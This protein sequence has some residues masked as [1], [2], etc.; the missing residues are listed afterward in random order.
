MDE[1]RDVLITRRRLLATGAVVAAS[2]ALPATSA[3]AKTSSTAAGRAEPLPRYPRTGYRRSRFAPHV[4]TLVELRPLGGVAVLGTLASIEDVPYVKGLAGDQ[5]AYTLRFRGPA[6][7]PL[8]GGV[9][10]I[11]HQHFGAVELYVTPLP[12][13]GPTRDYLAVI[14]R[15]VPRRARRAV[16]HL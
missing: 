11:R 5:D 10:G 1:D 4:G 6:A 7:Q 8:P 16:R 15:R 3:F 13:G 12:A 14:N 9:V 2:V